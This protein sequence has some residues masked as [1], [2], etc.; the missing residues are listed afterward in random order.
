MSTQT[1]QAPD[2]LEA[3]SAGDWK[4]DPS[5][6]RIGFSARH[7][8]VSRVK[9]NFEKFEGVIHVGENPFD[10]S[11]EVSI[12]TNS[13][14]TG[15]RKRDE[16]LV[17][18][19]FLESE[20][21]P[22]MKFTTTKVEETD[23]PKFKLYGDLTVKD[24]TR[25]VVLDAEYMGTAPDPWGGERVGFTA[26]GEID[27]EEFGMTWNVFIESGGVLVGRK[28]EIELDVQGVRQ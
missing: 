13:V 18:G 27:R 10:S 17:S 20:T 6:T 24:V 15:D 21:Y 11:V 14:N 1:V 19:D 26:R 12:E 16:H 5:H 8:M 4:L 23:L 9:G 22:L 2:A 3:P 25:P 28:V 7:L